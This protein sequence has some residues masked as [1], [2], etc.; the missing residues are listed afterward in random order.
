MFFIILLKIYVFYNYYYTIIKLNI[1]DNSLIFF[2]KKYIRLSLV[3]TL[4][5]SILLYV[6]LN[7]KKELIERCFLLR[8]VK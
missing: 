7:K 3:H 6:H 5:V 8:M 4:A 1:L 2:L